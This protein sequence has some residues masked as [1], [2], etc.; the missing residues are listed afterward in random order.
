MK[1]GYCSANAKAAASVTLELTSRRRTIRIGFCSV[2]CAYWGGI[3]HARTGF[4]TT[5]TALRKLYPGSIEV[6]S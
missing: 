6:L 2:L 3:K 4:A 5:L 1:C